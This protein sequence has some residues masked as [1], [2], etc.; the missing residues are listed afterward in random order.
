MDFV[1]DDKNWI[2][3]VKTRDLSSAAND[4]KPAFANVAIKPKRITLHYSAGSTLSGAVST[5]RSRRLSYH[6]LIDVDGTPFQTRPFT[7]KA[8]HAGRSNWKEA[9]NVTNTSSLSDNSI[10]ISF[11]NL[12]QHGFFN[13]GTW[14]HGFDSKTKTFIG[15][16]VADKDA[17]KA[18]LVY[19]PGRLTHWAPYQPRQLETCKD[20]IRALTKTF[21]EITELMGHHDI[22]ISDKPDP[23]PLVPLDDWR[24]EFKLEGG[25]GFQT[26]VKSADGELLLRDRPSVAEGKKITALKNGDTVHIRAIT[27]TN[28]SVDAIAAAPPQRSLTPWASVDTNGSNAHAGFVHM[29]SLADTPLHKS[30]KSKL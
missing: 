14:F 10:G 5:L 11:I 1:I 25:L 15:P 16:K 29:R 12:G 7:I 28:R 26:T 24:K 21:G 8:V 20:I 6:V 18:A 4:K 13:K 19:T 3:D 22:A 2:K 9:G 27:Y 23:G 30:L 17:T